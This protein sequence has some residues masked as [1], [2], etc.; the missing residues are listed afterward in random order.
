MKDCN[1]CGARLS[2][3]RPSDAEYGVPAVD[4]RRYPDECPRCGAEVR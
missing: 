1:E 3:R 2:L 4:G